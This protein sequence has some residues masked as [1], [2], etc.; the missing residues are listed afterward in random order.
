MVVFFWMAGVVSAM[1]IGGI[2]YWS[3]STFGF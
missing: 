2:G 3:W 1:V